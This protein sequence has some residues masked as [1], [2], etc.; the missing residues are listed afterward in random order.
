LKVSYHVSH[1][2]FS[3]REL[4]DLVQRAEQAEFDAAFSSDHFNPWAAA[5]GHSGFAWSWLGSALQATQ[6][7]TFSAITVPG[8][9]RYNPAVLAQAIGTRRHVSRAPAMGG[10]WERAIAERTCSRLALA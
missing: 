4:L 8:G 7:L 9:W 6:H 3:L 10:A 1:E 5:Q 2:Q